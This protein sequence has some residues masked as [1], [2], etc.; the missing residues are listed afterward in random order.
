MN[1]N[2]NGYDTRVSDME[3]YL[4]TLRKGVYR[5][6]SVYKILQALNHSNVIIKWTNCS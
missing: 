6:Q 3:L 1:F 4:P 5:A 2:V